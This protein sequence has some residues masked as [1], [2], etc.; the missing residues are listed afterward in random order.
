MGKQKNKKKNV[1]LKIIGDFKDV[2]KTAV[3]GNPKPQKKIKTK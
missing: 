2:I 1:P 3:K